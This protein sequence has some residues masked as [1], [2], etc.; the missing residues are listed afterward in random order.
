MSSYD[1]VLPI[2]RE[3][4]VSYFGPLPVLRTSVAPETIT[5]VNLVAFDAIRRNAARLDHMP[6]GS[7]YGR[8]HEFPEVSVAGCKNGFRFAALQRD[9]VPELGLSR[10]RWREPSRVTELLDLLLHALRV[11]PGLS[12]L[13]DAPAWPAHDDWMALGYLLPDEVRELDAL[14]QPLDDGSHDS[15]YDDWLNGLIDGSLDEFDHPEESPLDDL[16]DDNP[17]TRWL[18]DLIGRAAARGLCLVTLQ[19]GL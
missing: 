9:W 11:L 17:H 6:P 1:C 15:K 12:A 2:E 5:T 16:L 7:F 14:L 13:R 10:C 8:I 3:W 4:L 18:R 19:S